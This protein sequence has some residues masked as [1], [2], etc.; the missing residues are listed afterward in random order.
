MDI[1]RPFRRGATV[2]QTV[3]RPVSRV[4][5]NESDEILHGDAGITNQF[6]LRLVHM[7][8]AFL[9]GTR[10]RILKL[11]IEIVALGL[12]TDHGVAIDVRVPF[13]FDGQAVAAGQL[14][15]EFQGLLT[16]M[17]TLNLHL[18]TD[19]ILVGLEWN[20]LANPQIQL[21]KVSAADS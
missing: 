14:I 12:Q 16:G 11:A 8:A 3:I 19:V 21:R 20:D 15:A 1:A 10:A 7:G 5:D 9:A 2:L 18:E 17:E 4:H 13:P 6:L